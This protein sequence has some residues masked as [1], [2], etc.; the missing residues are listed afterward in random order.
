MVKSKNGDRLIRLGCCTLA[1]T[2]AALAAGQTPEPAAEKTGPLLTLGTPALRST[3]DRLSM[4]WLYPSQLPDVRLKVDRPTIE[5]M[6][7][8]ETDT[9]LRGVEFRLPMR[10]LW[11]GYET[12]V[13]G[14]LPRATLS[15]QRGF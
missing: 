1:A 6:S 5:Q 11:V 4:S 2:L 12:P 9:H 10:D 7:T 8:L 14:D 13:E 3:L 15:I